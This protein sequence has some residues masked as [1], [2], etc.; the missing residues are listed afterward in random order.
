MPPQ[1]LSFPL[2]YYRLLHFV[3]PHG[4]AMPKGLCFTAVVC[5]FFFLFSTS[6]L[7]GHWTDLNQIRTHIH[8]WLL[9]EK[10]GP[11]SPGHL[12]ALFGTDFELW[13]NI[14][15]QRNMISTILKKTCQSTGT[16]LYAFHIWWNLVLKRLRT[17]DEF[18][19]PLNFRTGR[20]C[21]PYHKNVT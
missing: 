6:N 1:I 2:C 3:S 8:L 12:P 17:V 16:P 14:S 9:F 21:Q 18:C 4:I 20:H 19:P 11:N 10:I 13:P 7:G 5:I 15:V